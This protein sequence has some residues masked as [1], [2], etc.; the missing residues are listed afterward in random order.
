MPGLYQ[1]KI[2]ELETV[3]EK[4]C[5]LFKRHPNLRNSDKLLIF[6]YWV[7]VDGYEGQLDEDV[8]L[9]LTSSESIRRVRQHIQND[10]GFFLP[11]DTEVIEG[12]KISEEAVRDWVIF[13]KIMKDKEIDVE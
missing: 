10:L 2:E 4:V 6:Y 13:K 12:R 7:I 9:K 5:W 8:I 3:E 11:Y 1:K